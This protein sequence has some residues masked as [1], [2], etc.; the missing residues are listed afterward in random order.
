MRMAAAR[1][2]ER[3]LRPATF[4]RNRGTAQFVT[5]R[6]ARRDLLRGAGALAAAS[7]TAG[8][9]GCLDVL[10]G[11]GDGEQEESPSATASEA[12]DPWV[13]EPGAIEDQDHYGFQYVDLTAY[14]DAREHF[15]EATYQL[16]SQQYEQK[17]LFLA[18]GL[19]V[20][21]VDWHLDLDATGQGRRSVL[22]GEF[23]PDAVLAGFES[24]DRFAT[25]ET[26][27]GYELVTVDGDGAAA[28]IAIGR[29]ALALDATGNHEAGIRTLLDAGG[30]GSSGYVASSDDMAELH[31]HLASADQ[32]YAGTRDPVPADAEVVEEGKFAGQV[33]FGT[34]GTFEAD[35]IES[36]YVVT[37][38]SADAVD[39]DAV[40]R[41]VEASSG[42]GQRFADVY[43]VATTAEGRSAVVDGRID[44]ADR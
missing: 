37:F 29:N 19:S 41:W 14:V 24:D 3:S 18:G 44:V 31:G 36:R 26:Y 38:E 2:G 21:D 42:D 4:Y 10:A 12:Y 16:L 40:D 33:A 28:S 15:Q 22:R 43:D 20:E 27:G 25:G 32:V 30:S 35:V 11:G 1:R 6:T 9:S 23:D 13:Y 8:L 39:L 5:D 34:A 17:T 7:A